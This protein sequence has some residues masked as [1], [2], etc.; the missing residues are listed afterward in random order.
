MKNIQEIKQYLESIAITKLSDEDSEY[1]EESFEYDL[2]GKRIE[3]KRKMVNDD[4]YI[5]GYSEGQITLAREL[6]KMI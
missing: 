5:I 6:L 4:E 3:N 2:R 1:T